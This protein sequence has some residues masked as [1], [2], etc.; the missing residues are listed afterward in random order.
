VDIVLLIARLLLAG[1]FLVAGVA[2]LAD[3]TGSRQ[4]VA[5]FGLPKLLASPLGILLPLVELA[6]AAALIPTS[7]AWWGA[8]GALALLLLF[9]LGI[10]VNLARGRKPDCRCFGQLHS[11]PAGW[12]T[13][14]RNGALAAAAGFVV[15]EGRDGGGLGPSAV[16]WLAGLSTAQTVGL[17]GG[18]VLLG[19]LIAQWWFL[20]HLL[21]QNG[22]LLVRL[23]ALEGRLGAGDA[24][25]APAEDDAEPEAGLPVGSAAPAFGLQGL[26]GETLTLDAL[27]APGKPVLLLFTDPNCGPCTALLP[28]IGRW[29]R[30]HAAELAVSVISRGTAEEN[31]AKSTEHGLSGVLLQQN[32]EVAEAYQAAGTPSA[33]IVR[34]DGTIGSPL[35]AGPDAIRALVARVAGERDHNQLPM[36]PTAQGEPCPNCGKAHPNGDGHAAAPAVPAGGRIGEP[37][38]EV[39]LADLAGETVKLKDFRGEKTLVLFWNPGCGFCS[40]MLP[41]LKEWEQSRPQGAPKLLVVS[42][43]TVEDN[44]AMGLSAP[45]VLDQNFAAGSAFGASGTPS[46]VLVDENGN[47]AS[48]LAV[49]APAVLALAGARADAATNGHAAAPA[50]PAAPKIGE[51]APPLKLPDLSG[52]TVNLAGFKG[53]EMLVLF[54]NPG[55]GFCQRMLP[56]LKEWEQNRPK[57]A[58]KLLV[59]SAGTAE[60]NKEMG[61]SAPVVLDQNFAAGSAFG[62]SGTPSAVLVDRKGR[63]ASELAVGAPA[64]LELARAG[65]VT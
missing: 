23:E 5:D 16:G 41:D 11:A 30:E 25:P 54:W 43:G 22:R 8:I 57:E 10:G 26:Y 52:K 60:A 32:W 18:L 39:T 17:V 19:L 64:V 50:V 20:A 48:E 40:Q 51:P 13:L 7:T 38:P 21:R 33:V 65:Q 6:V 37:A 4:A 3:R 56:D 53:N 29:Q 55:C 1:I 47:V 24:P 63:V 49:G 61:L 14:A 35:A 2:K 42:A 36:R 31:R 45:V 62:A 15:W 59:V 46:A 12:K 58:P 27:R 28:E 9:V 44:R 34:P